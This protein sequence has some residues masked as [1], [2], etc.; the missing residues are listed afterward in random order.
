LTCFFIRFI[1][2]D[3]NIGLKIQGEFPNARYMSYNVYNLTDQSTQGSIIDVDM[4]A[5]KTFL[6]NDKTAGDPY[7]FYE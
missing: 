5:E 1:L 3:P 7:G 2:S 4:Q 6:L